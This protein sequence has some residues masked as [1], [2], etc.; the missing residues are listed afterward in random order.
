MAN[1]DG[2]FS[3][4]LDDFERFLRNHLSQISGVSRL[5]SSIALREVV[6]TTKL[7]LDYLGQQKD[8]RQR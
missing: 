5:H 3:V 6:R 4:A 7:P 2:L 1:Y 8:R